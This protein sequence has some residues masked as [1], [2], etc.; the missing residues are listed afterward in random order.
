MS[1]ATS[2]STNND[3][4]ND[5]YTD[6]GQLQDEALSGAEVSVAA[7]AIRFEDYAYVADE[8][9]TNRAYCK[10]LLKS[11]SQT[12]AELKEIYVEDEQDPRLKNFA[13]A[14]IDAPQ[15]AAY[16]R[17]LNEHPIQDQNREERQTGTQLVH[18][19]SEYNDVI[20][21]VI[22]QRNEAF[23]RASLIGLMDKAAPYSPTFNRAIIVGATTEVAVHDALPTIPGMSDVAFTDTQTDLNG[24]DIVAKYWGQPLAIDT[25]Y[26]QSSVRVGRTKIDSVVMPHMTLGVPKAAIADFHLNAEGQ[27]YLTHQITTKINA[28]DKAKS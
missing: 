27:Q 10:K 17:W 6:Y 9:A 2:E 13:T 1:I 26:N 22:I 4:P 12:S 11:P 24:T 20:R 16:W 15:M 8:I 18:A 5:R 19:I 28:L 7:E 25:K 14:L 3:I 21:D 23:D